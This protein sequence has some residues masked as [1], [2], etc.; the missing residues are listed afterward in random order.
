MHK[1]RNMLMTLFLVALPV[2]VLD[3]DLL[4]VIYIDFPWI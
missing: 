1:I 2:L 4:D 3:C